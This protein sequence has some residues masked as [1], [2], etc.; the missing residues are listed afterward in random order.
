MAASS[1]EYLSGGTLEIGKSPTV[2]SSIGSAAARVG[3]HCLQPGISL[4]VAHRSTVRSGMYNRKRE[5][6]CCSQPN[7]GTPPFAISSC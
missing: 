3:G 6:E 1:I 7:D 4:H 5:N 2:E